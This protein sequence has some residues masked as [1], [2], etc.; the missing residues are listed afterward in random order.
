[1][2]LTV[3]MGGLGDG[4]TLS[5]CIYSLYQS[6]IKDYGKMANFYLRDSELI[7]NF[8]QIRSA[9][10]KV[11][12]LDEMHI[13]ANSRNFKTE[14]NKKMTEFTLITRK[15]SLDILMTTQ[16][17]DQIDVI[18]RR[19]LD[20]LVICEITHKD[21][22]WKQPTERSRLILTFVDYQKMSE[23]KTIKIPFQAFK[24]FY[25]HYDTEEIPQ[26]FLQDEP[27]QQT[28]RLG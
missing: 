7:T 15:K 1:M 22:I 20:T 8:D 27:K 18:I 21:P 19:I 17:I 11:I 28:K 5:M 14:A 26:N 6:L 25:G 3:F 24:Q 9:K 4:K 13:L 16:H 23:L 2:P 10:K 12:C